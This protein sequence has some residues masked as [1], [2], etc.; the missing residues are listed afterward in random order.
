M[1][2]KNQTKV[3]QNSPNNNDIA[4]ERANRFV[5]GQGRFRQRAV[6]LKDKG[7]IEFMSKIRYKYHNWIQLTLKYIYIYDCGWG[8]CVLGCGW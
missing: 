8:K 5:D 3:D 6:R 1:N 7:K 2:K 4:H